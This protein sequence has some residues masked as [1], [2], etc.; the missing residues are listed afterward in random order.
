ML[1]GLRQQYQ[2]VT[3]DAEARRRGFPKGGGFKL[4]QFDIVLATEE[5]SKAARARVLKE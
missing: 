4:L 3:D 2:D 1:M 5:E